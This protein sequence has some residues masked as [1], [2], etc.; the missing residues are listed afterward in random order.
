M[1]RG[2]ASPKRLHTAQFRLYNILENYR[3]GEQ[4]SSGGVRGAGRKWVLLQKG[5][6]RDPHGD[7]MFCSSAVSMSI[8]CLGHRATVLQD[9]SISGKR[10][11]SIWGSATISC[12]CI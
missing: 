12:N 6:M 11:K 9:V 7:R 3:S 4:I 2:K 8:S 1:L 5:N 10:V